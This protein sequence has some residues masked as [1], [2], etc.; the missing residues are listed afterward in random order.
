MTRRN[1]PEGL[2]LPVKLDSTS[3]GEFEPVPLDRH[4]EY[5]NQLALETATKNA[6]R[7]G[8]SR[9]DFLVSA[10]GA[11]ASSST[12]RPGAGRMTR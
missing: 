8:V 1:D 12:S 5:A 7:L 4:H 2:R 11:A 3:N 10:S 6:K 9:R